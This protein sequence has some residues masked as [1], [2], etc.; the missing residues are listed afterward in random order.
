MREPSTNAKAELIM[1]KGKEVK[2]SRTAAI[3]CRCC[4]VS[5]E[6]FCLQRSAS[7]VIE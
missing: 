3:V 7:I 6:H 2:G 4:V 1:K 5:G